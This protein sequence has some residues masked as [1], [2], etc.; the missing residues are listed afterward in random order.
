MGILNGEQ[1]TSGEYMDIEMLEDGLDP[2]TKEGRLAIA[3]VILPDLPEYVFDQNWKKRLS[4][5][6]EWDNEL[7][8]RAVYAAET[9]KMKAHIKK[10]FRK[11]NL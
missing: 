6:A 9:P 1:L 3:R 2:E 8:V 10:K 4:L 5:L 7:F 11:Y